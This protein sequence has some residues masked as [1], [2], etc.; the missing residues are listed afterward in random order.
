MKN[1]PFSRLGMTSMFKILLALI[2]IIP[3][4]EIWLMITIG[5][6]IGPWLTILLIFLTGILGVWLAKSQ[7]LG[8]LRNAQQKM[9]YGQMPGEVIIDGLCILVG[10]I[11]LIIPGFITDSIGL[12][13]MVPAIRNKIKPFIIQGIR[14]RMAKGQFIVINRR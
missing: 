7:G 14:N 3:A 4:L 8:A 1:E 6:L 9:R 2:I 10:G 13:L 12:L 11:L 5:Q